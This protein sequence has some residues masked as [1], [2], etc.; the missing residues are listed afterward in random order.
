MSPIRRALALLPFL[1]VLGSPAASAADIPLPATLTAPLKVD[2]GFSVGSL[3]TS[4]AYTAT[5]AT[6]T[7]TAP[8]IS[9]GKGQIF[10]TQICIQVHVA[11]KAPSASC[12]DVTT[13]T[14][15]LLS[16]ITIAAPTVTVTMAR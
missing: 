12:K 7:A 11:G 1:I 4:V 14:R 13:D 8:S 15:S 10:K 9:L 16:T 6:A 5:D 2:V 3:T